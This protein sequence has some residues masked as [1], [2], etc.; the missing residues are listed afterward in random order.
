MEWILGHGTGSEKSFVLRG[1]YTST[2]DV[3][4]RQ[5]QAESLLSV[6][7]GKPLSVIGKKKFPE[8]NRVT[9]PDLRCV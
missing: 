7:D 9:G 6:P 2:T 5:V 3:Y 8:M 1:L 4:K